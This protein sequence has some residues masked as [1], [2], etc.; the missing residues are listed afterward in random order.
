MMLSSFIKAV[1]ST[2]FLG[3]SLY[4][5][6]VGYH[7]SDWAI[8]ALLPMA[9]LLFFGSWPLI[10]DPWK[11][12]L[13]LA[14]LPQS[15]LSRLLS[16]KF[17]TAFLAMTFVFVSVALLAWQCLTASPLQATILL[18][19]VFTAGF[20]FSWSQDFLVRHFRQPFARYWATSLGT[21]LVAAPFTLIIAWITWSSESQP[22]EMLTATFQ[23][24]LKIGIDQLPARRGLIA[25]LLSWLY[26]YDAAK[27][28][29]V[30][31][32]KEYRMLAVFFSL[33]AALLGF[34]LARASIIITNFI[35]M[36]MNKRPK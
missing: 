3:L 8:L 31:Q 27:L 33:D 26:A 2:A 22:G 10:I 17:R 20:S 6:R 13:H 34:V 36:H 25:E 1:G 5:W 7:F 35:G 19:L 29:L 28:W 15:P 14:L 9:V 32:Y 11:E 30:I 23:E 18:M 21:W 24:A 4:L 12:R 16:G